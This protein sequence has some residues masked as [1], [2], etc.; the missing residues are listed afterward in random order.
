MCAYNPF[1]PKGGPFDQALTACHEAGIGLVAMK[2]MRN[3]KDVPTRLPQFDKLG[4]TV[5]QASLH[6][7]WSDPRISVV[8]NMIDNVDQMTAS[9]D[10]ARKYNGPLSFSQMEL[11]EEAILASNR[12]MCTGCPSCEEN[13][14]KTPLAFQDIARYLT[15]YEKDGNLDARSLYQGLPLECRDASRADLAALRD[16]CSL[17]VNYP[18]I[19]ARAEKYFS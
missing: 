8:C 4:L 2:T 3:T 1:Y 9:T 12:T 11:L 19:L 18:S 5:H 15:Y 10:A 14:G 7:A 6:S 17:K 16:G 13:S